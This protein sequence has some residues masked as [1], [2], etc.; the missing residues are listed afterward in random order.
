MGSLLCVSRNVSQDN[1]FVQKFFHIGF[2][3]MAFLPYES[4][5]VSQDHFSCKFLSTLNALMWLLS[6]MCHGMP[7]EITFLCK[8]PIILSALIS[9]ISCMCKGMSFKISFLFKSLCIL[10]KVRN[11]NFITIKYLLIMFKGI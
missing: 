11:L 6:C 10:K 4:K 9:V 1:F 7:L 8:Y 5:N 3:D 2:T